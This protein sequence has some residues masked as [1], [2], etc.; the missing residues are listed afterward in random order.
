[1][2]IKYLSGR[3]EYK[4]IFNWP[5][6]GPIPIEKICSKFAAQIMRKAAFVTFL[7]VLG[8]GVFAQQAQPDAE[9][10]FVK[11]MSLE[12]AMVKVKTQ[13]RPIL[14]DF[15]TDWCGWC[16]QM[17]KTTYA[18]ADLAAYINN[19]FYPVKFNAERKDTFEYLGE[20]Y[21]PVGNGPK[22]T[23]ALAIKLLQGKL[24][25]PTTLFLNNYDKQKNEFGFSMLAQGYLEQNKLEPILIFSLENVFRNSGYE[26]FKANFDKAF[27]DTAADSRF[28]KLKW[29]KP[30]EF[31]GKS[32]STK[33][34]TMVLIHTDWCNA[35]RVMQR[36]SFNDSLTEKYIRSK[37]ELVD[38]VPETIDPL[39]YKGQTYTNPRSPQMPFHQLAVTLCRNS[40]TLPSLVI[41][42][43]KMEVLDAIPYYLN[44]EVLK[45]IATYYGDNVYKTTK[46]AD[47]MAATGKK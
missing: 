25:Y 2:F 17:M 29:L 3:T 31:F 26:D 5:E 38:F 23:N 33:K 8:L 43:E 45:N 27:F 46:W 15:Y 1:L 10:S 11:W 28:K 39:V 30:S 47:F 14:M 40:L 6:S 36:T 22:P 34:K 24:M 20:K 44:P 13:P 16:K 9:G 35:C 42:D 19:N 12:D 4:S 18:N 32:D 7:L 37:Y 41:L 21:G